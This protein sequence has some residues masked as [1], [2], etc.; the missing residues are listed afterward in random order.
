ML[1]QPTH[2]KQERTTPTHNSGACTAALGA[3]TPPPTHMVGAPCARVDAVVQ[4]LMRVLGRID[5][6][7]QDIHDE[8]TYALHLVEETRHVWR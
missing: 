7:L 6:A 4:E 1:A 5:D 2:P 3:P 8:T